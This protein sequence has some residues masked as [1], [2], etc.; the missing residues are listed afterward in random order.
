M[1]LT[2]DTRDV[3]NHEKVCYVGSKETNARLG[4][5][6]ICENLVFFL[7]WKTDVYCCKAEKV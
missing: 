7:V 1:S 5:V 6:S 3:A 4:N 2:V